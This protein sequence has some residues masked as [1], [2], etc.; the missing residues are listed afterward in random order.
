MLEKHLVE[1]QRL[2]DELVLDLLGF[3][4]SDPFRLSKENGCDR[5]EGGG[6]GLGG[7]EALGGKL[8]VFEGNRIFAM[9]SPNNHPERQRLPPR[10]DPAHV[11]EQFGLNCYRGFS[12]VLDKYEHV[13]VLARSTTE[14]QRLSRGIPA[15]FW[16]RFSTRVRNSRM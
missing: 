12:C 13:N 1:D 2:V 5:S 14:F 16:R 15:K 4:L 10:F 9:I 3:H 11:E 7:R 8:G 6:F